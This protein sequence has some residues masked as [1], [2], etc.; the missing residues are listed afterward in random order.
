MEE[1]GAFEAPAVRAAR[2]P[3]ALAPPSAF[4][5]AAEN[6]RDAE[7]GREEGAEGSQKGPRVG[8]VNPK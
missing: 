8:Q 7:G 4:R 5:T 1:A 2:P 6:G 3:T